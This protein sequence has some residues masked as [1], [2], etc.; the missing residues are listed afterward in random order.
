M[1]HRK[2][3]SFLFIA[4]L[5]LTAAKAEALD[6]NLQVI[7]QLSGNGNISVTPTTEAE[8]EILDGETG[9]S[10]ITYKKALPFDYISFANRPSD[11]NPLAGPVNQMAT[12][13]RFTVKK[14]SETEVT[15]KFSASDFNPDTTHL[16]ATV[17]KD[18]LVSY[19]SVP[20]GAKVIF[21]N[22]TLKVRDH[23]NGNLELLEAGETAQGF[24]KFGGLPVIQSFNAI[25]DVPDPGKPATFD[26]GKDE[27]VINGV[28]LAGEMDFSAAGSGCSLQAAAANGVRDLAGWI[29]LGLG[30]LLPL[31][32]R[33]RK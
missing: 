26:D 22:V 19:T 24:E 3:L 13:I 32:R 21:R 15:V 23:V 20:L 28:D 25:V 16:L 11:E 30:L 18:N 8:M 10:L 29:G 2:L 27:G 4:L 17:A 14:I 9:E 5:A 7:R 6:Y 12:E 31:R 1:L 33:F